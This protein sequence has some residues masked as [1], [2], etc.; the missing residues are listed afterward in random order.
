MRILYV[1]TVGVTMR[2]FEDFIHSL[3]ESGNEVEI[4]CNNISGDLPEYCA[5]SK[6]KTH[7]ISCSRSPLHLG[8]LKAITQIKNL[9]E[10]NG[11]DIVH[12]HTPIAAFCTRLACR[13][14]R[15]NG[16][17]V[18]YTA[19]GFHFY[20]GAPLK[21]WLLFY[22]AEKLCARLTDVLIT[23]NQED[24]E[25][26]QRKLKAK[27]VVYVPGVGIDL[28]KFGPVATDVNEKRIS[29]GIPKD[30]KLLLSVGELNE[31]KNHET[32]IRAIA[33]MKDT[34]YIIAGA[35]TKRDKLL[36]VIDELGLSERVKLLGRRD[37]IAELCV[38]SDAF[39]FPSFREGLSV[40]LMEAMACCLP[41]A[42]SKIRGN[43]DL[44]DANGGAF[45]DPH[46][47]KSCENAL[48]ELFCKDLKKTGKYN[49]EKVKKFSLDSVNEEMKKLYF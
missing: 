6:I 45:F 41:C 24:Y 16:T 31:N 42:V 34:H 2:F 32:V 30:A 39:V 47:V 37:D 43:T 27:R 20:K 40:A 5:S 3:S 23:I 48:E 29:L 18:F 15:K 21:N 28:E 14:A 7:S 17:R 22:T 25:L 46:S 35:G 33:D 19:H 13:K 38:A 8:N 11:Y 49:A 44:I 9:V 10:N 4:A 26:A 12:C 1:T 36:S